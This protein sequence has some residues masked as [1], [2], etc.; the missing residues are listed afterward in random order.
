MQR[1]YRIPCLPAQRIV[2]ADDC[3]QLS[4]NAKVQMGI[5]GRQLIVF[6]LFSR[7]N[8]AALIFKDKMCAAD[9]DFFSSTMLEMPCATT[10]CTC[11]WY[12][13]CVKPRRFASAT[14]ALAIE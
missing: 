6:F 14:T 1:L 2:D 12:S 10:Y 5:R 3:R 13:S 4:I 8:T 11:E 9:D 7:R